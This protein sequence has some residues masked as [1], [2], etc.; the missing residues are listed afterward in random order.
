MT[1]SLS[2]FEPRSAFHDFM[3]SQLELT[4]THYIEILDKERRVEQFYLTAVSAVIDGA[5]LLLTSQVE[6]RAVVVLAAAFLLIGLLG[7]QRTV[8]DLLYWEIEL[9]YRIEIAGLYR[10]FKQFDP[11]A[12][13]R[14]GRQAALDQLESPYYWLE[15]GR[16]P[17]K[18]IKLVGVFVTIHGSPCS[19]KASETELFNTLPVCTYCEVGYNAIV[20]G[21]LWLINRQR[22]MATVQWIPSH[23]NP[24]NV[25]R[26]L[27]VWHCEASR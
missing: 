20:E 15:F 2:K 24:S 1:K 23:T 10:Y 14:F 3:L 19:L 22:G 5:I 9:S 6:L 12:F 11:A 17:W 4:S 18:K 7:T 26:P 13:E 27:P 25:A 21:P 8:R 16:A